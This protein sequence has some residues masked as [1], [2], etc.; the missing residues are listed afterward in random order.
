[1]PM[2]SGKPVSANKS[3]KPSHSVSTGKSSKPSKFAGT[4]QSSI[5]NKSVMT[6][7]SVGASQSAVPCQSATPCQS[8]RAGQSI[9]SECVM[10]FH[11]SSAKQ[12]SYAHASL[13]Q[14]TEYKKRGSSSLKCNGKSLIVTISADDPVALRATVNSYLRLL[15]VIEKIENEV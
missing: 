11:F 10:Q 8:A 12:A 6:G 5:S 9:K 14:E 15:S 2:K 3:I 7:K 1:M 13:L 4:V